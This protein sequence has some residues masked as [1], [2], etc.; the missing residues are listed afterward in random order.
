MLESLV[1]LATGVMEK[2]PGISSLIASGLEKLAKLREQVLGKFG[3]GSEKLGFLGKFLK[4]LEEKYKELER[5]ALAAATK[6]GID[7]DGILGNSALEENPETAKAPAG[8]KLL[9]CLEKSEEPVALEVAR[10]GF[11]DIDKL[12]KDHK[13]DEKGFSKAFDPLWDKVLKNSD[14]L[15][16]AFSGANALGLAQKLLGSNLSKAFD[17]NMEN[18][19]EVAG[20]VSTSILPNTDKKLLAPIVKAILEKEPLKKDDVAKLLYKMNELDFE[21]LSKAIS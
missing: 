2:V 21:K 4:P 20:F 19:D 7:L 18:A 5:A 6:A 13:D 1:K 9:V 16:K 3:E 8:E 10:A 12:R 15:K 14:K 11:A 17:L